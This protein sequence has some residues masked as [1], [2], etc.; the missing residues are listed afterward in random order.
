MSTQL[1]V[2]AVS[3]GANCPSSCAAAQRALSLPLSERR[4]KAGM[5]SLL[6]L[7]VPSLCFPFGLFWL[8]S[9]PEFIWL[10]RLSEWP[11]ELWA[12]SLAGSAA[13]MGGLGDWIF[14]RWVAQCVVGKAER[15]CEL[16]ALAGGGVPLFAMMSRASV[17][18][19][20]QVWLLPVLVVLIYTT[21]LI[22]YDEF[23]YHRRR[24]RR[25]EAV[26]H[27]MLVFGNGVAFL[28]WAHWCFVRGGI[29][30]HA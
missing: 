20:P 11:W 14:H 6:A 1:S 22:C 10:C 8:A 4:K 12:I 9:K 19:N 16:L 26:L 23:V 15:R 17:S 21:A 7:L 25:L 29:I 5:M 2:S 24:C 27:R 13:L 28:A 30:T 18:A 3:C